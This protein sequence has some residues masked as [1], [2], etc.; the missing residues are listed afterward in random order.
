MGHGA[1][2]TIAN[3]EFRIA[4]FG[5]EMWDVGYSRHKVEEFRS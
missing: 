1:K 4:D 3:C 5:Y 2:G